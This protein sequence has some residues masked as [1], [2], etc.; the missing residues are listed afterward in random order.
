[1]PETRIQHHKA[2]TLPPGAPR[3]RGGT[4]FPSMRPRCL[5]LA[6]L[7][8]ALVVSVCHG[9]HDPGERTACNQALSPNFHQWHPDICPKPWPPIDG[10]PKTDVRGTG[11][12]SSDPQPVTLQPPA[13]DGEPEQQQAKD[14][15]L[16]LSGTNGPDDLQGGG[17]NDLLVGKKGDD[18]L[19]GLGGSDELRGGKGNDDLRGGR[20]ADTLVGGDGD[21]ELHGGRGADRL[22]D[23][24]GDDTYSGGPGA[25][26]FVF[27]SGETG[28]KIINDFGD[29]A[30][31]IV[32]RTEAVAWPSVA[33]I[34]AGVVA[35]GDRYLVYT[36]SPGLTVETGHT[37][38]GG[39]LPGAVRL[40][41]RIRDRRRVES[42][43]CHHSGRRAAP[44]SRHSRTPA[45]S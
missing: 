34:I 38:Q 2:T 24:D 44:A 4:A 20:G 42:A 10:L 12:T 31:R 43:P 19:R 14:P 27:I 13:G 22:L 11:V 45:D 40:T 25:D 37:S 26:R 7:A 39:G 5:A 36:L 30:D 29:G 18:V 3:S 8:A 15:S 21:D 28:D 9:H 17:G 41:G 35:Q 16:D 1:M 32:L 33:D 23:G 6:F